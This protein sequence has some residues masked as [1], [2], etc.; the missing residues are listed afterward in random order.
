MRHSGHAAGHDASVM[1][2]SLMQFEPAGF[3]FVWLGE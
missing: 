2:A 3:G 1:R